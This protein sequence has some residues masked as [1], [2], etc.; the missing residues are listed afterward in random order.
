MTDLREVC[1]ICFG[2]TSHKPNPTLTPESKATFDVSTEKRK[3]TVCRQEWAPIRVAKEIGAGVGANKWVRIRPK[4][5]IP[6]NIDFQICKNVQSRVECPKGQDCSYAHSKAELLSWNRERQDEPRPAPHINGP[7]QYQLCKHMLNSGNC[8]YGQR[9]TFAH[10][11]DEL[12][13]WLKV[14]ADPGNGPNATILMDGIHGVPEYRCDVCNLVCTGKK[15]LDDHISGARHKQ[16]IATRALHAYNNPTPAQ[17]IGRNVSVRRRPLLSFPINGY[18]L[19]LHI[20]AGRRCIYGDYCTFAHSQMELEAWNS[21]LQLPSTPRIHRA[22]Q[23]GGGS[24]PSHP[25]MGIMNAVQGTASGPVGV[26]M[27]GPLMTGVPGE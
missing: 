20:S 7:Y 23:G 1:K 26:D 24:Q 4:P 11:D 18:K 13:S 15:Q 14:Q 8:P 25:A 6:A 5:K 27:R 10:S 17:P 3:C 19:C 16:Q 21:Q 2:S 22:F 12:Q 9:C